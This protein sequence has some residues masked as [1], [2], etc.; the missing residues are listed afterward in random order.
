MFYDQR[1][2]VPES[3]SALRSEYVDGFR[4]ILESVT[5]ENAADEVDVPIDALEALS[6]GKPTA[7]TLEQAA[8]IQSLEDGEPDPQT[9][10]ELA[11]DHLLLG[12]TT[13]VIDV[14]TLESEVDLDLEAKEIQQRIE[15]RAPMTFEEFIHVQHAIVS[16]AP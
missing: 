14:D 2:T 13:A 10:V 8:A 6:A 15:R 16:S 12:M 11:C 1:T 9:I 3:P 7:L 5:L 4:E